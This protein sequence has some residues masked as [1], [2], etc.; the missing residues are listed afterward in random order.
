MEIW[1]EMARSLM[2][3]VGAIMVLPSAS[4]GPDGVIV[5]GTASFV[6][7]GEAK[8]IIT[9]AHV[10]NRFLEI[11]SDNPDAILIL[12]GESGSEPAVI[13][14]AK[15]IC[16]GDKLLD[17]AVLEADLPEVVEE[18]GKEYFFCPEWPPRGATSEEAVC[19]IGFPGMYRE[20]CGGALRISSVVFAD[21][22]STVSD[23]N[24]VFVDEQAERRLV[25]LN[26]CLARPTDLGGM[27]GSAIYVGTA[28]EPVRLVAIVY[29]VGIADGDDALKAWVYG[30]RVDYLNAD[31]TL[32]RAR[33][34]W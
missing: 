10:Y 31:G 2:R 24:V 30:A 13:T 9:C 33:M 1:L 16:V 5:Q 17:I 23:R 11:R 8:L 32:N 12:S 22:V 21:M 7:T 3:H 6:D 25:T 27:S 19:T 14:D 29:E 18:L 15:C 28:A 34:P 4:A 20:P 26:P